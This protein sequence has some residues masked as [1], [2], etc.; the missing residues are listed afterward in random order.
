RFFEQVAAQEARRHRLAF[1]AWFLVRGRARAQHLAAA[2]LA[3][4]V[5]TLAGIIRID[6]RQA[7]EEAGHAVEIGLLPLVERMVVAAGTLQLGAQENPADRLGSINSLLAVLGVKHSRA[8]IGRPVG[9]E[10]F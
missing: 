2:P 4:Y 1:L 6:E 8:L 3:G 10:Y 9:H 5:L 7:D